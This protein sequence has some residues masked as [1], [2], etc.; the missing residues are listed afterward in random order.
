MFDLSERLTDVSEPA[1]A[2]I[3]EKL[4]LNQAQSEAWTQFAMSWAQ[5]SRSLR[6]DDAL[7]SVWGQLNDFRLDDCLDQIAHL[8]S[9]RLIAV[10]RLA[11]AYGAFRRTLTERQS[12]LADR[13][14]YQRCLAL[15]R[16]KNSEL[17]ANPAFAE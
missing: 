12:R 1:L 4:H 2:G 7:I 10:R 5:I 13:Y 3:R 8:T 9:T 17:F 6:E 15:L 14:L 16:D 11:Y